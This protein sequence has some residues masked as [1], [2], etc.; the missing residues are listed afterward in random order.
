LIRHLSLLMIRV[1][2]SSSTCVVHP[3]KLAPPGGL[4]VRRR[5]TKRWQS[6]VRQEVAQAIPPVHHSPATVAP[7]LMGVT[8]NLA[9]STLVTGKSHSNRF[10]LGRLSTS[11][12]LPAKNRKSPARFVS[13]STFSLT[14]P[15]VVFNAIAKPFRSCFMRIIDTS[16]RLPRSYPGFRFLFWY[17]S[18]SLS[19]RVFGTTSF[20][21]KTESPRLGSSAF[22]LSL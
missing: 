15:Q 17:A 18:R 14:I 22:P 3:A 9:L 16:P 1:W 4:R 5:A 19:V 20:P 12:R 21:L 13:I 8:A 7:V 11:C 6:K 10:L 2:R